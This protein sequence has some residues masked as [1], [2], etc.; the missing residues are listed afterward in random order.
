MNIVENNLIYKVDLQN[1]INLD[2]KE[3]NEND[4]LKNLKDKNL[5]AKIYNYNGF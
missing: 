1:E 4:S 3:I 2:T 5:N